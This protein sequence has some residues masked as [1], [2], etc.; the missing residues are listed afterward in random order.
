MLRRIC[1][2]LLT[3]VG[4]VLLLSACGD[5][6]NTPVPPSPTVSSVTAT[7]ETQTTASTSINNTAV[8][9]KAP[10]TVLPYPGHTAGVQGLA[11]SPDGKL[12]ASGDEK[13]VLKIWQVADGKLLT[14]INAHTDDITVLRFSPDG[15]MRASAGKDAAVKLWDAE[16]AFKPIVTL[17]GHSEFVYDMLFTPD[18]QNLLS[19]GYEN[20]VRIWDVANRKEKTRLNG[21]IAVMALSPNGKMLATGATSAQGKGLDMLKIWE[22]ESGKTLA[23]FS[24]GGGSLSALTFSPDNR[25]LLSVH[26]SISF[27]TRTDFVL[28][29]IAASPVKLKE[30]K[31]KAAITQAVFAPDGKTVIGAGTLFTGISPTALSDGVPFEINF[32]TDQVIHE[33]VTAVWNLA[34]GSQ[35]A[36]IN[37]SS[38]TLGLAL[39]PNAQQI[40]TGNRDG[41]ITFRKADLSG[42]ERTFAPAP[43]PIVQAV[44][45]DGR[46]IATGAKEGTLRLFASDSGQ[47]IA[48]LNEHSDTIQTI[49]FS[50]DGKNLVTGGKDTDIRLWDVAGRKMLGV[51]KD[52]NSWVNGLAF[53]PEGKLLA[54]VSSDTTVKIWKADAPG[55]P[56]VASF[57][58]KENRRALWAVAFSPDGK[59]LA[60]GGGQEKVFFW[61]IATGK[62]LPALT[63]AAPI[64]TLTFSPDGKLLAVAAI[65]STIGLWE[66]NGKPGNQ[67]AT[68]R[69][70]APRDTYA[71]STRIAYNFLNFSR[72]GKNLLA[73]SLANYSQ[74]SYLTL[75]EVAARRELYNAPK[76][77][78]KNAVSAQLMPD[79]SGRTVLVGY[80]DGSLRVASSQNPATAVAVPSPTVPAVGTISLP[81]TIAPLSNFQLK[82][83]YTTVVSAGHTSSVRQISFTPDGASLYS[84]DGYSTIAWDVQAKKELRT[85]ENISDSILAFSADSSLAA[86][87]RQ[88]KTLPIVETAT[89]KVLTTLRGLEKDVGVAAFALSNKLVATAADI[90]YNDPSGN[91]VQIWQVADGKPLAKFAGLPEGV[92]YL[93]FSP[94]T[95]VLAGANTGGQVKVWDATT[96]N[97]IKNLGQVNQP[98]GLIF[99][100]DGKWLASVGYLGWLTL[101]DTAGYS[102][103][104]HQVH[105]YSQKIAFSPDSQTIAIGDSTGSGSA[106]GSVRLFDLSGKQLKTFASH[107]NDLYA[108]TFSPDGKLLAFGGGGGTRQEGDTNIALW[109]VQSGQEFAMLGGK[110]RASSILRLDATTK[111]YWQLSSATEAV[112]REITTGKEVAKVALPYL[113]DATVGV[114]PD[115]KTMATYAR[116]KVIRLYDLQTGALKNSIYG[117][118]TEFSAVLFSADNKFVITLD[119]DIYGKAMVRL[120]DAFSTESKEVAAY[121]I[122]DTSGQTGPLTLSPDGKILLL[123]GR[124]DKTQLKLIMLDLTSGKEIGELVGISRDFSAVSFSLD[125]QYIVATD[126]GSSVKV[127]QFSTGGFRETASI[128][129]P[130]RLNSLAFS[131]DGRFFAGLNTAGTISFWDLPTAKPLPQSVST[132]TTKYGRLHFSPDGAFLLASSSDGTTTAWTLAKS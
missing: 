99:S 11:Y 8:S 125:G 112:R 76:E 53:S 16:A 1:C 21:A 3:F 119:R 54:S 15:K 10:D 68:F 102:A 42:A 24:P 72:D 89:G 20:S 110:G 63:V 127:W 92:R 115:G 27:D 108:L 74:E 94:D 37:E 116:D 121:P 29:E 66:F 124:S 47:E 61:E 106:P 73:T 50:P 79:A 107:I 64:G 111:T 36:K 82:P 19:L 109:D 62:E 4:L 123:P 43:A 49:V 128:Q 114:S 117:M 71:H 18:G 25:Q 98:T 2:T 120:W 56:F 90:P 86:L 40:A 32:A 118:R 22:V 95:K 103:K 41:A 97:E 7:P 77:I 83:A 78:L 67:V 39:S 45:P 23:T 5:V 130:I 87:R 85:V 96:G 104:T 65:D 55:T 129:A 48:I 28:W 100:P 57:T 105:M 84:N 69:K 35:L 17:R 38:P 81:P 51:W 44:S 33:G 14:R 70:P 122:S 31:D 75:W 131:P 101:W 30:W 59:Y 60:V 13:G 9:L 46:L 91:F 113:G 93:V 58:I 34:D 88:D 6:T 52:H 132:G 12:L 126:Q 80:A 26:G